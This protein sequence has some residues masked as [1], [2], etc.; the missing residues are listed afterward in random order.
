MLRTRVRGSRTNSRSHDHRADRLDRSC[1]YRSRRQPN[2]NSGENKTDAFTDGFS[3]H[4]RL[5]SLREDSNRLPF[6]QESLSCSRKLL[7]DRKIQTILPSKLRRQRYI[8]V[9]DVGSG[10]GRRAGSR[11]IKPLPPAIQHSATINPP[12][13]FERVAIMD[14]RC[15][16]NLNS[17][18]NN[19][20]LSSGYHIFDDLG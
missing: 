15:L 13:H 20:R 16:S 1:L 9:E 17:L 6:F 18:V 5:F 11:W 14:A 2:Q 4:A 7:G 19:E 3:S 8:L 12:H 10:A